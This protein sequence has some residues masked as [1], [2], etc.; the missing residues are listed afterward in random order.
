[1]SQDG[2]SMARRRGMK[3]V[4]VKVARVVWSRSS[5]SMIWGAV[6][7]DIGTNKVFVLIFSLSFTNWFADALLLFFIHLFECTVQWDTDWNQSA[8]V[9]DSELLKETELIFLPID[10]WCFNVENYCR[11]E[12]SLHSRSLANRRVIRILGRDESNERQNE[13]KRVHPIC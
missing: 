10:M 3:T 8:S 9:H 7:L 4:T 11:L 13:K 2:Q 1:M 12:I 5:Y 6:Q